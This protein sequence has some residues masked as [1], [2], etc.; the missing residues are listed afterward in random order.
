MT[1]E[2]VKGSQVM[3]VKGPDHENITI[4]SDSMKQKLRILR[5][6]TKYSDIK[7]RVEYVKKFALQNNISKSNFASFIIDEVEKDL[8]DLRG[9]YETLYYSR[10]N[11]ASRLR[12]YACDDRR[13]MDTPPVYTYQFQS[14]VPIPVALPTVTYDPATPEIAPENVSDSTA[15]VQHRTA[16]AY[17]VR[18]LLD[19]DHAKVWS[20]DNFIAQEDCERLIHD[21]AD[22]LMR[23]TV[24]G[25]GGSS[26]ISESR[27]AQQAAYSM[28]GGESDPLWPLYNRALEMVNH[29]AG[30]N[31]TPEGQEPLTVIQYNIGDEYKPHCDSSCGENMNHLKGG[32][33]ATALLYCKVADEGGATTFVNSNIFVTPKPGSVVFFSY[34]GKDDRRMDPLKFTE[35]TGCPVAAGEKWI[36]TFWMRDGVNATQPYSL[37]GTTG[38]SYMNPAAITNPLMYSN[39]TTAF[40][41]KINCCQASFYKSIK[42]SVERLIPYN[43]RQYL[44]QYSYLSWLTSRYEIPEICEFDL[45]IY[46]N[47]SSPI[48]WSQVFFHVS[49]TVIGNATT[50]KWRHYTYKRYPYLIPP[51]VEKYDQPM[52][53]MPRY[54]QCGNIISGPGYVHPSVAEFLQAVDLDSR[55][56]EEAV[57]EQHA[58]TFNAEPT[59]DFDENYFDD[60]EEVHLTERPASPPPVQQVQVEIAVNT[61][62]LYEL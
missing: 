55:R 20:I 34:M 54:D 42:D 41:M 57:E 11:M 15:L 48:W 60:I 2:V 12:T 19:Q 27:K 22:R 16:P 23:A 18:V 35:H 13:M 46:C 38:E 8:V 9:R 52:P 1:D 59:L 5:A 58:E 62:S 44:S 61:E 4:V 39:A 53:D 30:F 51:V 37:F 32:R 50:M 21:A 43:I 24:S 33:I 14:S 31:I 49:E 26:V 45:N 10:L 40:K 7:D 36:T 3:F 56:G 47:M 28:S 17:E 29:H 6:N 25:P